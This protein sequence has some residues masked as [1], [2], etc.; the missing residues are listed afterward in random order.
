MHVHFKMN[1]N[2]QKLLNIST[3]FSEPNHLI[4]FFAKLEMVSHINSL[5]CACTINVVHV[6]ILSYMYGTVTV[7]FKAFVTIF[8]IILHYCC[9]YSIIK[10][11]CW[12]NIKKTWFLCSLSMCFNTLS[13]CFV[14]LTD[15][16]FHFFSQYFF[17][18]FPS[19]LFFPLTVEKNFAFPLIPFKKISHPPLFP[20][21]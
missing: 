8:V 7:V 9:M 1:N 5:S 10:F 15:L 18:F 3:D 17:Y 20:E 13:M 6:I 11:T 4:S 16:F 19:P 12:W 2:S 14:N 21:K